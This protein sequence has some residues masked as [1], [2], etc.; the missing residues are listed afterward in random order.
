MHPRFEELR[1]TINANRERAKAAKCDRSLTRV[2]RLPRSSH[3]VSCT[4][5][6]D[7]TIP[8]MRWDEKNE[9]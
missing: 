2:L 6:S 9:S 8:T 3:H 7:A 1:V 4:A 5:S